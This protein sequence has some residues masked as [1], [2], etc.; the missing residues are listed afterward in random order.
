MK[1]LTNKLESLNS[2]RALVVGDLMLDEYLHGSVTRIS[3]E[4]PVPVVSAEREDLIPGG[5]ANVMINM[6]SMGCNVTGAGYVGEDRTGD[7][8]LELLRCGQIDN[9]GICRYD[10]SQTIH[11]TRILAHGQ[12]VVRYDRDSNFSKASGL[13]KKLSNLDNCF[14]VSVVSDYDK[15]TITEPVM[16]F[17]KDRF[18]CPVICDIKP[19]NKDIFNGV[20]CITPN[21]REAAAMTAYDEHPYKIAASLKKMMN[22]QTV[23]IT[24]SDEGIICID[25]DDNG[26]GY[27]AYTEVDEHDPN[28][29]LD[30][31]GAGDTVT[32]VL[33]ACI[34]SNISMTEAVF[35]SN[36]A[37]GVVVNKVGTA[38]CTWNELIT[39]LEKNHAEG[40][41]TPIQQSS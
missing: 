29:R 24:L 13:V 35:I 33:A 22:L 30:V 25:K 23:V 18:S 17:L 26:F 34:G 1:D 31:T 8:L 19:V 15:G 40:A 36:V 14:D 10:E 28:R 9:S 16:K 38:V 12:H 11:K 41:F 27:K 37:A 39:E 3:P 4:A 32:S 6:R 7:E 21:L 5:A 2:V 20:Y